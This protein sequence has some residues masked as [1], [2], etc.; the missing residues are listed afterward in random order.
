MNAR[1]VTLLVLCTLLLAGAALVQA[2]WRA[3]ADGGVRP[4]VQPGI[5][6][7]GNYQLTGLDQSGTT[8]SSGGGYRLQGGVQPLLTGNGCCCTYVPCLIR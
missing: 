6:A 7:G 4:V 5:A 8:V 3:E 2:P 1:V